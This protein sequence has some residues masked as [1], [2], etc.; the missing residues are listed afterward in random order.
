MLQTTP[1]LDNP[2]GASPPT[3]GSFYVVVQ[4]DTLWRIASSLAPDRLSVEQVMLEIIRMN[5]QAF[6]QQNV[7]G[8]KAGYRLALPLTENIGIDR[9]TAIDAVALQNNAWQFRDEQEQGD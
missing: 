5:P 1:S 9:A 7:N 8:L 4:N 2:A 3:A 6:Q